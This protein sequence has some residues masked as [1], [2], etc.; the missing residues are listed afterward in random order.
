MHVTRRIVASVALLSM[1]CYTYAPATLDSIPLNSEV[2]ALLSTEAQLSLEQRTGLNT[3][4]LRGELV[5]R[6]A[7]LVLIAVP[8]TGPFV[9]EELRQRIDVAPQDILRMEVRKPAPGRT[10]GLV[11]GFVGAGVLI[12]VLGTGQSNPGSPPNDGGGGGT[13]HVGRSLP[14]PLFR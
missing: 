13:E 9:G 4:E 1:G 5:E 12:V 11:A 10:T 7:D 14:I 6:Q 2:S 3:R 8:S